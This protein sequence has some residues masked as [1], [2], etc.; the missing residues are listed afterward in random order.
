M[1]TE[2]ELLSIWNEIDTTCRGDTVGDSTI[3][4]FAKRIVSDEDSFF[5]LD[6]V[7]ATPDIEEDL[8]R[9][10]V[11]VRRGLEFI[12]VPPPF[13]L[14]TEQFDHEYKTR[15][16]DIIPKVQTIIENRIMVKH[17]FSVLANLFSKGGMPEGATGTTRFKHACCK[18]S[19]TIGSL[20]CRTAA[21]D[22]KEII[23]DLAYMATYMQVIMNLY[24]WTWDDVKLKARRQMAQVE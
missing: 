12:H 10:L 14:T 7:P 9:L 18:L 21:T 17:P 2:K 1:K 24:G 19:D 15:V 20:M 5:K 11:E 23:D 13:E 8:G 22:A 6:E 16:A 3:L 4:E